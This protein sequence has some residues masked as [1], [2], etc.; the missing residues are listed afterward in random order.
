MSKKRFLRVQL[1][2]RGRNDLRIKKTS[3]QRIG[4]LGL[5]CYVVNR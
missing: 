4:G 5:G 1:L 3:T 2:E